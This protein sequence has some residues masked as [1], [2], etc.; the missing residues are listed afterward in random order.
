MTLPELLAKLIHLDGEPEILGSLISEMNLRALG[1]EPVCTLTI[2]SPHLRRDR[3]ASAMVFLSRSP[4]AFML[5]KDDRAHIA[6][7]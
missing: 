4:R 6:R 7:M 2:T 5:R 1:N 3:Q